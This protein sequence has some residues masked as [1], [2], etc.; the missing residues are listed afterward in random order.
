[1]LNKPI[2]RNTFMVV[3]LLLTSSLLAC[4]TGQ[5][6]FMRSWDVSRTFESF[7]I[8]P[9]YNYYYNGLASSPSA[10]VGIDKNY[11]LDSPYWHSMKI[12]EKKLRDIIGEI[13]NTPGVVPDRL[14]AQGAKIFNNHG[15][16]IGIWYSAWELPTIT[17]STDK[18][19]Y[20][21][22]P[23]FQIPGPNQEPDSYD[24]DGM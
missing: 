23:W 15:K 14:D 3:C 4:A 10:I 20:M 9:G 13:Q 24:G 17:F 1:M 5:V 19:F 12:D 18:K 8:V 7:K 11:E 22:Q 2:L 16:V 6:H 21:S